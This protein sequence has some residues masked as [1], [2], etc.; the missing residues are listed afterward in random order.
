M[1]ATPDLLFLLVRIAGFVVLLSAAGTAIFLALF[2]QRLTDSRRTVGLLGWWFS[3]AAVLIAIAQQ[4]MEAARLSGEMSGVLDP[5][6]QWMALRSSAG[7]S[8]ALKL[9]GALLL[10]SGTGTRFRSAGAA[11]AFLAAVAF[12]ATGH[13]SASPHSFA[14][15]AVLTLHLLIVAFWIGSLWPLYIAAGSERAGIVGPLIESFSD[16]AVWIVPVILLAGVGLTMLLVPGLAVFS[17]PYGRL[18]LTKVALFAVLLA[19]ATWNKYQ[20]GPA[21]AAGVAEPFRRSVAM[22]YLLICGVLAVT[23]VMTTFFSPEAP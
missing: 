23:A 14:A 19:I 13:V 6:M 18:L 20:L 9:A 21:C 17:Q 22:E 11:G 2:E 7:T 3:V 1:E 12:T 15:A 5:A 10:A 8:F 16:L 4:A